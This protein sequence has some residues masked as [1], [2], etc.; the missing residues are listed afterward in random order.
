MNWIS[1]IQVWYPMLCY[2]EHAWNFFLVQSWDAKCLVNG[3]A[4]CLERFFLFRA[5]DHPFL[6]EGG[7]TSYSV[8][9]FGWFKRQY[10]R[11]DAPSDGLHHFFP[12]HGYLTEDQEGVRAFW[13]TMGMGVGLYTRILVCVKTGLKRRALGAILLKHRVIIRTLGK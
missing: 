4:R 10:S 11:C 5:I 12:G 3:G 9:R 13:A 1:K 6:G 8:N 7:I 2:L